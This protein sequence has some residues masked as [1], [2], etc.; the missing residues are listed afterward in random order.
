MAVLERMS[1]KPWIMSCIG[2]YSDVVDSFLLRR[3]RPLAYRIRRLPLHYLRCRRKHRLIHIRLPRQAK[4]WNLMIQFCR[5]GLTCW[6][7]SM[8]TSRRYTISCDKETPF[9]CPL[10]HHRPSDKLI[11]QIAEEDEVVVVRYGTLRVVRG[12]LTPKTRRRRSPGLAR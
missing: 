12:N 10:R 9:S 11:G 1:N 2:I 7:A 5:I 4:R 6:K 3:R 8:T